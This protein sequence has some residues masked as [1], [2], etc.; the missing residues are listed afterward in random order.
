MALAMREEVARRADPSA[1]R[2]RSHRHRHRPG[3]GRGGRHQQVHPRPVGDTV[4]TASR[5]ESHG[6]PGC[7]QVTD[8]TYRRLPGRYHFQRRGP[9]PAKGIGE[10]VTYFLPGRNQ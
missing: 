4:N 3:G 7:I 5:I 2:C 8:P 10:M 6:V 9:D 1:G